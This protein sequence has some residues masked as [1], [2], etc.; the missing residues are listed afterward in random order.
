[1]IR[2]GRA[3]CFITLCG[4]LILEMRGIK[5]NHSAPAFE[6]V[7]VGLWQEA[8]HEEAALVF[9]EFWLTLWHM[10]FVETVTT[11]KPAAASADFIGLSIIKMRLRPPLVKR[12][13]YDT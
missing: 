6:I 11:T 5:T 8:Y 12:M 7:C 10:I 4:F 13:A 1:M 3:T 2:D 9:L